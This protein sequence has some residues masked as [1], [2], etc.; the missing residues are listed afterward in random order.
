MNRKLMLATGLALTVSLGLW[1]RIEAASS[2]HVCQAE[3]WKALGRY[4]ACQSNAQ[5]KE[6]ISN[7]GDALTPP[8]KCLARYAATWPRLQRRFPATSCAA[9]RFVDNGNGTVTD[10]LTGL[11]W[12]KK[13]QD[14]S[15]H[16]VDIGY[17]WSAEGTAADGPAFTVFLATLNSG[18]CLAGQCDW[19]LPTRD[20]V[21]T[22]LLEP[23][24][25]DPNPCIDGIFG[26]TATAISWSSTSSQFNPT[27][28]WGVDFSG[29]GAGYVVFG[30]KDLAFAVRA[31]RGGL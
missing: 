20:E 24:P 14:S 25:C 19:R 15:V 4:A 6:I 17:P 16:R 30:K 12:E 8:A 18:A 26:P 23:F 29:G 10:N 1:T 21:Q 7:G 3:R 28:A 5:A 27:L 9:P 2:E 13:T 31:V 22:I 11:V